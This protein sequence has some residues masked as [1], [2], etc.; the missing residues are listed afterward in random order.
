MFA[1]VGSIHLALART[2][3]DADGTLNF[4]CYSLGATQYAKGTFKYY[5]IKEVG[6]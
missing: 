3:L 1:A 6:G 4:D 5:V 2:S